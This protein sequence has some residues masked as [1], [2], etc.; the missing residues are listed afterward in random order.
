M[1]NIPWETIVTAAVLSALAGG[2][3]W[4]QQAVRRQPAPASLTEA[5]DQVRQE[6]PMPEEVKSPPETG[7]DV[8]QAVVRANPFSPQRYQAP[9]GSGSGGSSGSPAPV[10]TAPPQYVYKGRILMGKKQRAVVEDVT[11]KK[12]FFL[13]VGQDLSGLKV[14]D[15]SETQVVLSKPNSQETL[16]L[17]LTPKP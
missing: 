17:S 3:W 4:W 12:T 10:E 14:L 1:K 15:I 5:W 7:E 11:V 9:Q 13:E 8:L 2:A 16:V 6:F